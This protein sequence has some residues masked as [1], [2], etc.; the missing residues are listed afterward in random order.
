ML[1]GPLAGIAD[2]LLPAQILWI[3]LMTHGLTGVAFGGQPVDPAEMQRPPRP[4]SGSLFTRR[5]LSL[6]A[7]LA[8]VLVA[9]SLLAGSRVGDVEEQRTLVFLTLGLGQLAVAWAIRAPA[10]GLRLRGREL[11]LMVLL[12]GL[13]MVLATQ[14]PPLHALLGTTSLDLRTTVLAGVAALG[15]GLVAA[16]LLRVARRPSAP[17]RTAHRS[18]D[19]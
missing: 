10:R 15:P 7:V 18:G 1:L 16:A 5:F 8:S 13:L 6:L 19:L 4:V 3:N 11:E 14:T 9:V 2:P 12:A 17:G